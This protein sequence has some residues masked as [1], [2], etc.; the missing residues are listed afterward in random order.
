MP[1]LLLMAAFAIWLHP[2]S[3]FL[4]AR[5]GESDFPIALTLVFLGLMLFL[6][7]AV[8]LSFLPARTLSDESSKLPAI[9]ALYLIMVGFVFFAELQPLMLS[10]MFSNVHSR[11]GLLAAVV[12]AIHYLA[13]VGL[14]VGIMVALFQR[15]L[16]VLLKRANATSNLSFSDGW[17]DRGIDDGCGDAPDFVEVG[18]A[19]IA[20]DDAMR[21]QRR[22]QLVG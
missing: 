17:S 7:W 21:R 22:V 1:F 6:L 19:G 5:H 8:Y 16:G 11:G 18:E 12:K 4:K 20:M 14:P 10:G 13:L 9:A 2:S 15:R 3:Y